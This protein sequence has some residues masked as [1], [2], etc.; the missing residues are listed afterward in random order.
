MT[1]PVA[2]VKK[3]G[4]VT[5]THTCAPLTFAAKTGVS[6]CTA[7]VTN[8]GSVA[9][10]VD[11][12]VTDQD[13]DNLEFTNI[14]APAIGDQ[15]EQRRRVERHAHAGARADDRVHHQHHR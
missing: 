3:Q 11:L 5:L 13:T 14:S 2:F 8:F 1:I 15:E 12:T 6:H 9:A 10:N 4:V 7:T